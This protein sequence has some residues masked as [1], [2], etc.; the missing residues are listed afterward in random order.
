MTVT[1]EA[2]ERTNEKRDA[3]LKQGYIPAIYY[4]QGKETKSISVKQTEFNKIFAEAGESTTIKLN[5]GGKEL[6]VLIHDVQFDPVRNTPAHVDFLVVDMNKPIEVSIPLEFEGV[7]PAVRAGEGVLVKVMHDMNISGL[8]K[9]LPHEIMVDISS[10]A[11]VD[12]HIS[13]G[14][15][16]LPKGVSH[17]HSDE[18]IIASISKQE[19]E[20]EETSTDVDLSQ[21]EVESKGKQDVENEE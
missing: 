20:S 1:I 6:D 12:S 9:D 3:L 21:I 14:D 15:I 7:S 17:M 2:K 4:G 19:E 18:D 16:K 13:V 8:P 10:L 11:S 5:D